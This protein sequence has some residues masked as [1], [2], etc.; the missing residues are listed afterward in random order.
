MIHISELTKSCNN[1]AALVLG[2]GPSLLDDIEFLKG[3][4]IP[5]DF[6][7]DYAHLRTHK[8]PVLIAVN[9]H[10]FFV[11]ITDPDFV[12]FMDNP[13]YNPLLWNVV[14]QFGGM[15]VTHDLR[16][17][18]VSLAGINYWNGPGSGVVAT[19]LA[20][21]LGCDPVILCGMDC[22]Q[23]EKKYCHRDEI[24]ENRSVFNISL[25]E[26]LKRWKAGFRRCP[27]ID[28]VRAVSG[29]LVPVFGRYDQA[30]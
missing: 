17:T 14:K 15:K 27:G 18:D 8:D 7:F 11:G 20:C 4:L 2:G 3:K 26:H 13:Q 16:Y 19:W 12:V 22:Y 5:H 9:E 1:R 23:G 10:P 30:I 25:E 24:Y 6:P 29:P 28:R 21:Y